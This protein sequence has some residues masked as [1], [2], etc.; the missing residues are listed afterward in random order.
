MRV[1]ILVSLVQ[2][3]EHDTSNIIIRVQI[4][5]ETFNPPTIYNKYN[6]IIKNIIDRPNCLDSILGNIYLLKKDNNNINPRNT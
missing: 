5:E 2:Q 1:K 3:V 6:Y 4:P